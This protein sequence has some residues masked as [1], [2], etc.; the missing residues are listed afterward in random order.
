MRQITLDIGGKLFKTTLS[1]INKQENWLFANLF[2]DCIQH[3]EIV[4]IGRDPQVF[5]HILNY[6]RNGDIDLKNKKLFV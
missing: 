3:N 6:L 2:K 4:F 5:R 1:T